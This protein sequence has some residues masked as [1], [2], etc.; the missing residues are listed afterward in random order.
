MSLDALFNAAVKELR[1]RKVTFAVAGGLAADLYRREPRLTMD[2]DLVIVAESH[3]VDTAVAV[4]ESL[5]LH[6]GI[7]RKADLAGGPLFAIRQKRT[8]PC[9]VVGRPEGKPFAEGVDILLPAIPWARDAVRRA[10]ANEVDFGFG[11]VPS[12]TLEDV[13]LAK[14]YALMSAQ[15][16]AKDLD[17]LQSIFADSC[18]VDMPYL[19]GQMQRFN[20]TVPNKAKPFLPA[21]LLKVSRSVLKSVKSGKNTVHNLLP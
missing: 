3:A 16:R 4:I 5:G 10:Q 20:I 2:V 1:K 18:E 17:D 12:L 14:L 9:M 11:P 15:L 6:A 7:A 21:D 8:E 13:I 19:A